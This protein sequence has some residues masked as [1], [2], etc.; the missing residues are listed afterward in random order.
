VGGARRE[1]VGIAP[2]AVLTDKDPPGIPPRTART[3][4]ERRTPLRR[5]GS[6]EAIAEAVFFLARGDAS[7]IVA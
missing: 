3:I 6:V 4:R 1:V 7:Y 2:G 5:M